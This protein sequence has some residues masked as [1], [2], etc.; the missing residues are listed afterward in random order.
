MEFAYRTKPGRFLLAVLWGL[1]LMGARRAHAEPGP[2]E[3]GKDAPEVTLRAGVVFPMFLIYEI[4]GPLA[5]VTVGWRPGR[6]LQLVARGEAG[7]LFFDGA[8]RYLAKVGAGVRA[9]P[10]PN[11]P[12]SPWLQLGL[13]AT[14]HVEHVSMVLPERKVST[15]DFGVEV[16]ADVA[17]GVRILRRFEFGVG[18]DHILLPTSYYQVYT[19]SESV[20]N[21]GYASAWL[22]VKL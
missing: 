10:W 14:G 6:H 3:S 21:R 9:S 2:S 18:W 19:G 7:A 20:P 11:A 17:I 4:P 16:T 13:G 15:T 22:G 1:S 8:Q 5:G 12:V